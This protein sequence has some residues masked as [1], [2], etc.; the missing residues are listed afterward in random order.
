MD[1]RTLIVGAAAG[2]VTTAGYADEAS[3]WLLL[4][5]PSLTFSSPFGE[6][7]TSALA[8]GLL[9]SVIQS[10]V[11]ATLFVAPMALAMMV[12]PA[13]DGLF[14]GLFGTGQDDASLDDTADRA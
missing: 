5:G 10:S 7:G 8:G 9:R 6:V 11:V 2:I 4:H 3:T 12:V 14:H 1:L 13:F